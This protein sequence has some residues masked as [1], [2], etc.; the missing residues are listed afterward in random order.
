LLQ[1][2]PRWKPYIGDLSWE[3]IDKKLKEGAKKHKPIK[4]KKSVGA[5]AVQVSAALAAA[6][7]PLS[8]DKAMVAAVPAAPDGNL[9][10]VEAESINLGAVEAESIIAAYTGGK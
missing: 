4:A 10:A 6:K 5:S 3:M 1:V 9:G 2:D 7:N 8:G